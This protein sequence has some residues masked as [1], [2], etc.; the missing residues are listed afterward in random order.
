MKTN[1]RN[2]LLAV[3][4]AIFAVM[5]F[6]SVFFGFKTA[7]AEVAQVE[8]SAA[9]VGMDQAASI[10]SVGNMGIRFTASVSAADYNGLKA[11]YGE[12]EYGM[13]IA[14][15]DFV[16]DEQTFK[17]G[18][19]QFAEGDQVT[20]YV[21][22]ETQSGKLYQRA[23]I[24]PVLKGGK[25]VFK[26]AFVNI[27]TENYDRDFSVRAYAAVT[28][29][30]QTEKTYV[31]SAVAS[32]SVFAVA[33]SALYSGVLEDDELGLGY[34]KEVEKTV[35]DKYETRSVTY[36]NV[37]EGKEKTDKLALGDKIAFVTTLS[38]GTKTLTAKPIISGYGDYM[39]E[40]LD[41]DGFFDGTYTI[42]K[43][44]DFGVVA[45]MCSSYT[46][47]GAD[48][49]SI[50]VDCLTTDIVVKDI[51]LENAAAGE[52]WE[53]FF[54]KV[55]NGSISVISEPIAN[56]EIS[57]AA[58]SSC[59]T[60]EDVYV[61]NNP[62]YANDKI[63]LGIGMEDK[64]LNKY[65][66]FKYYNYGYTNGSY[67][68]SLN[69][70]VTY[71]G[72]TEYLGSN[73]YTGRTVRNIYDQYGN[74]IGA[75]DHYSTTPAGYNYYKDTWC[76]VEISM[77]K[78][79]NDG[80]K[81]I[82]VHTNYQGTTVYNNLF[83]SDIK[84]SNVPLIETYSD[85]EI[86]VEDKNGGEVKPGDELAFSAYAMPFGGSE[87]VKVN[88]LITT[89]NGVMDGN[90]YQGKG[91]F[92]VTAKAF[93]ATVTEEV[94][95]V[96]GVLPKKVAMGLDW[97]SA[98][99]TTKVKEIKV[100][101]APSGI[102]GENKVFELTFAPDGYGTSNAFRMSGSSNLYK[103][104]Y[105]SFKYYLDG[106]RLGFCDS[107]WTSGEADFGAT[108]TFTS[109]AYRG[110]GYIKHVAADGTPIVAVSKYEVDGQYVAVT[111]NISNYNKTWVTIEMYFKD[112]PN[113][114][115]DIFMNQYY[116][117]NTTLYITD[118]LL[119]NYSTLA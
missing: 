102:S 11:K 117:S 97:W 57:A 95:A 27:A 116:M 79:F 93:G 47:L 65:I 54:T 49:P 38:N 45:K 26:G 34:V 74:D 78:W 111:P 39:T 68:W 18:G 5:S 63:Y 85:L 24:D 2:K 100:S 30:G 44:E 103:G 43:A 20:E 112:T 88:A 21:A 25:Y 90:I 36:E 33:N 28:E 91:T 94:V 51:T 35:Y 86:R 80:K 48:M 22:G 3:L 77:L 8:I 19:W 7:K 59:P 76:T 62:A 81:G 41:A 114:M 42:T 16:V 101:A 56:D 1:V 92:T 12:V 75:T 113:S 55:G 64:L 67:H 83:I 82:G 119:T 58:L 87:K 69:E 66:S 106:H 53:G 105:V 89:E 29:D 4:V 52:E 98:V 84:V 50:Q 46:T 13:I 96:E 73:G 108:G 14:P 61:I 37:T 115:V 99:G 70:E 118:L 107:V 9:T 31:Y 72:S 23:V 32:R 10:K 60:G 6:M 17:V 104:C 40:S 15:A 109:D 110:N 71:S